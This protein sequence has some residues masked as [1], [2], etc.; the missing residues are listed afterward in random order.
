M[1]LIYFLQNYSPLISFLQN[2]SPVLS[3]FSLVFRAPFS[4]ASAGHWELCR[5]IVLGFWLLW[6]CSWQNVF[7]K[8]EPLDLLRLVLLW[9]EI[10]S[11]H[12]K[13]CSKSTGRFHQV[14][15]VWFEMGM[16]HFSG[17]KLSVFHHSNSSERFCG[18]LMHL[19]TIKWLLVTADFPFLL[20]SKIYPVL[21]QTYK[22]NRLV[23]LDVIQPSIYPVTS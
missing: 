23:K 20:S 7:P 19:E 22:E 16:F 10:F 12:S 6:S 14:W 2:Y 1:L 13:G 4:H 17:E 21:V 9:F 15:M 3:P 11:I 18:L 8:M 5:I